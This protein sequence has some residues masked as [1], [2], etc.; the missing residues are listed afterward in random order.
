MNSTKNHSKIYFWLIVL[1]INI[2]VGTLIGLFRLSMSNI[3][4]EPAFVVLSK[5]I[6]DSQSHFDKKINYTN[7]RVDQL[8]TKVDLLGQRV[9]QQFSEIENRNRFSQKN[10][11]G[12]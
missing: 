6:V 5:Q 7:T 10:V 3:H 12:Q 4:P 9:D 11:T 2:T 8:Q 1:T